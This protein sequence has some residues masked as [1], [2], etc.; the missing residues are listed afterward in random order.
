MENIPEYSLMFLYSFILHK[1]FY[2]FLYFYQYISCK[3]HAYSFK[4]MI[5]RFNTV[6]K[7]R[8]VRKETAIVY[9]LFP[10]VLLLGYH[11]DSYIYTDVRIITD[12]HPH[13]NQ[14]H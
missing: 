13:I 10:L 14:F 5:D 7:F 2:T 8:S 3:F 6:Y 12:C 11:L 4:W 1:L 9:D